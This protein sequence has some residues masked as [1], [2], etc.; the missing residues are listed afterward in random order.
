MLE[1]DIEVAR[2]AFTLRA[3][4]RAPT[5]GVVA[6]FGRSGAGKSTLVEALAGL[7]PARGTIRLG[8]ETWL[9]SSG[10]RSL[11]PE[12]RRVGYV[13][14]DAKLFPHL[15]VLGNLGYGQRRARG[16]ER[17]VGRDELVAL[18]GLGALLRRRPHELS[19]GERQ[20]VALGRALL[21]QPRLL[22]LDEP[23]SALDA[24]RRDE[25][26]PYLEQLRDRW[27]V[28]MVYV[29]HRYEEVLRLATHVWLIDAGRVVASASPGEASLDERLGRIVGPELE[30]AVVDAVVTAVDAATRLATV[31]IGSARLRLALEGLAP[32]GSV[33]LHVPARDVVVATEPPHGLSIRNALPGTLVALRD[34][35]PAG[36]L[37]TVDVGAAHLLARITASAVR[38]LGLAA[39]RPVWALVKAASLHG[40]AWRR[41]SATG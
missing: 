27:A 41:P 36:V 18:L 16:V 32:G 12:R 9:D 14:Q 15:D 37:A 29:S 5:P 35:G 38:E 34:D 3:S 19:G 40:H 33:R 2:G 30:G 23:L 11:P 24:E 26:L 13:F 7:A 21:S 1:I 20:R 28:P 6:A 10:G 22:L 8:D 31:A 39:G 25:V 4:A 17:Y